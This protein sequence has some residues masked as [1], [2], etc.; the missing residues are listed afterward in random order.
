MQ[1]VV[2]ANGDVY[3]VFTNYNNAVS[4]NDN[5]NDI[6]VV[7]STNGGK[8]FADPQLVSRYYDLPDC[9]TYTGA[10]A[11]RACVPTSPLSAVSVFRAANYP[12]AATAPNDPNTIY[13]T[14]GSFI[15]PHSNPTNPAGQGHCEPKG[16]NSTTFLNLY[17][18]VD[19][20]NGC[21]NDILLSVSSDG[22]QHWSAAASGPAAA[23][24]VSN[25]SSTLA[26]Q[27]WQWAATSASG[28]LA[29]SYYD[30]KYGDDVSTGANDI[31]LA[32]RDGN[33]V[34]HVRV[35][36]VSN[37]P[38]TEF[39]G[40]FN[41]YSVFLGDYSGLAVSGSTAYPIWSDTRNQEFFQCPSAASS[42]TLCRVTNGNVLGF[43]EDVFTTHG[44]SL[45]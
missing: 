11:F 41:G 8:T 42:L 32:Q 9:V 6:L 5:H 22:G 16:L 43:D 31:T 24:V 12:S 33:T 29:V 15:N 17:H 13:V 19:H 35:T 30:R 14:F 1:P 44:L 28:T 37:P 20:A 3:V 2:A 7:K 25:E 21:N 18:G 38:A 26:S 40:S 45:P 23:T 39:P 10:D 36:S 34:G 27:W 4:G